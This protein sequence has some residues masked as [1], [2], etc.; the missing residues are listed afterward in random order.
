[1]M[2]REKTEKNT[3]KTICRAFLPALLI[4][5]LLGM[6][7]CLTACGEED[8]D[9]DINVSDDYALNEDLEVQPSKN[10]TLIKKAQEMNKDPQNF[11]GTW[12]ATSD[13]AKNYYGHLIIT[14]NEDGTF[15]ADVA[16]EKFS[17]TWTKIDGG[18]S[19][20]SELMS[21]KLFYGDTCEMIIDNP[22]KDIKVYLKQK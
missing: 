6:G 7:A 14:I 18:I 12:E 4:A 21:G 1:M 17:G 19:Y 20:T 13:E 22:E 5:L 11:L 16:D 2:M 15:D 10:K 9:E 3:T 8:I